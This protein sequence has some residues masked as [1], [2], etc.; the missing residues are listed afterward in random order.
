MICGLRDGRIILEAETNIE[1][2]YLKTFRKKYLVKLK[3]LDKCL[4]FWV[5]D[6]Y[7]PLLESEKN[8][9]IKEQREEITFLKEIIT[10]LTEG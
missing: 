9:K 10:K 5:H 1:K 2:N 6:Y 7:E 8:N 3:P 4:K